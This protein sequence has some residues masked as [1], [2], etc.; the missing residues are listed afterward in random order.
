M[1]IDKIGAQLYTLH[2]VMTDEESIKS[3]LERLAKIGFK[4]VQVS[5][6]AKIDPVKLRKYCDDNGLT[7]DATHVSFDDILN[8]TD[9][10][11]ALHDIYGCKY[12]GTGGMPPKDGYSYERYMEFAGECNIVAEKLAKAGKTFIYHNHSHEFTKFRGEKALDLLIN[13][14]ISNVHFEIDTCWAQVGCVNPAKY[15]KNLKGRA[16]VIHFKDVKMDGSKHVICE[17]GVGNCEFPEI[18]EACDY[19]GTKHVFIEQDICDGD[20]YESL[21]ISFNY[22]KSLGL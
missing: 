22:L 16:D 3:G 4:S 21:E 19:A 5:G 6:I 1:T 20:P 7:I 9:D 17:L 10:I 12:V 11:I 13:N 2:N 8:N 14:T 15:I 18:I